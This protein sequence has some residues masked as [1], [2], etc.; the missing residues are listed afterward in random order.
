LRA[1]QQFIGQLQGC[2]HGDTISRTHPTSVTDAAHAF[3]DHAGR[4]LKAGFVF[5]R[6]RKPILAV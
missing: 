1:A 2:Q 4:F 3:I 5:R 6:H